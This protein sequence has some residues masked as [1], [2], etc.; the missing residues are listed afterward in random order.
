MLTDEFQFLSPH[1]PWIPGVCAFT[2]A[3]KTTASDLTFKGQSE[4]AAACQSAL[5]ELIQPAVPI[6]WLEQ[7]HGGNAIRLPQTENMSADG[8]ITTDVGVVCAMRSADCLPVLLSSA[9]GSVVG[10][11]HAGWKGLKAGIIE[12]T[13]R[14]LEVPASE[15]FAWIGPAISARHYEIGQEVVDQFIDR[16]SLTKNAF[17]PGNEGKFYMDLYAMAKNALDDA[18]VPTANVSGGQFCTYSDARLHSVRR[19]GKA[20]GRMATVIWI[21]GN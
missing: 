10:V 4:L 7:P 13:V 8:A 12:A 16:Q 14:R 15:V 3:A 21:A 2:V 17:T 1:W 11:A 9:D 6:R 18:G 5:S 20:A 19:D